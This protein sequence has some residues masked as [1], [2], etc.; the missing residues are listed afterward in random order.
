[1]KGSSAG[2]SDG[3]I[4]GLV[5][6]MFAVSLLQ[7]F[8]GIVG[9]AFYCD[10]VS[11]F[12]ERPVVSMNAVMA[13][14]VAYPAFFVANTP[15]T[16]VLVT[17]IILFAALMA[18]TFVLL[19]LLEIL[20][21]ER[22]RALL[23]A[24]SPSF[25]FFA[26][27]NIDIVGVL[28]ILSALYL[29]LKQNWKVSAA[30]LGLA[31]A[32]K[33]FPFIYIPFVWLAQRD[34][35]QRSEYV[36]VAF[37]TWLAV[38]LPFMVANLSDWMLFVNVQSQWGIE[39]SWMIFVLPRMSPI[40]HYLT[41]LLFGLGMLHIVRRRMPLERGWFAATLLFILVSFK[42]PPQ[43]FL[44]IL[45]FVVILGFTRLE[46]LFLA[47]LLNAL[48]IVTWFTPWLNAGDPLEASSPTQWISLVRE[49]VLFA[50][51]VYLVHPTILKWSLQPLSSAGSR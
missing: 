7:K 6:M 27:Y 2:N 20:G 29:A 10:L 44:Y 48:I 28:F 21:L 50:V 26:Y 25:L 51:L 9:M 41:Y 14:F 35:K 46:P 32:T 22:W 24:L 38:N 39:N 23:F 47:D 45:P 33:V 37:L 36:L 42:F 4:Y 13:R 3:V 8:P 34:W 11:W 1:M 49:L 12:Y 17:G 19:K 43:Y 5:A 30:C 40:A 31:V 15:Q 18:C 16:Y